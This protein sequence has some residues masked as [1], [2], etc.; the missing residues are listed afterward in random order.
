MYYINTMYFITSGISSEIQNG[1]Y[2]PQNFIELKKIIT[3]MYLESR[4]S[5]FGYG[6]IMSS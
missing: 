1:V 3:N 4:S 6:R 5:K 2:T